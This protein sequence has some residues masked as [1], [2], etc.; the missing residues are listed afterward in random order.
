MDNGLS[1]VVLQYVYMKFTTFM[2]F[3]GRRA[4]VVAALLLLFALIK[5]LATLTRASSS[6]RPL[7]GTCDERCYVSARNFIFFVLSR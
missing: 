7:L 1:F 2:R 3:L 4:V 5:D 6:A